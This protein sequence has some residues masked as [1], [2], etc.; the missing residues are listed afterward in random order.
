MR[1]VRSLKLLTT[2]CAA[3][4]TGQEHRVPLLDGDT[5]SSQKIRCAVFLFDL[6]P[7]RPGITRC[8]SLCLVSLISLAIPF[9]ILLGISHSICFDP[10]IVL[11]PIFFVIGPHISSPLLGVSLLNILPRFSSLLRT[12]CSAC[13]QPLRFD[14]W[15]FEWHPNS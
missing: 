2:D 5:E 11:V 1:F 14:L 12:A 13:S 3:T 9:P 6:W 15:I 8:Q 7:T 10:C 4:I